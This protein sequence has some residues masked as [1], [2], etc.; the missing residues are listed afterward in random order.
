MGISDK[1]EE[2]WYNIK[3]VT[4]EVTEEM[5]GETKKQWNEECYDECS[6]ATIEQ[7]AARQTKINRY[8]RLNKEE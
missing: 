5:S 6:E 4:I 7:N 3:Q 1:E 8:K 2:G